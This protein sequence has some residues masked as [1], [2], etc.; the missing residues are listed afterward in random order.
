MFR[1]IFAQR[2]CVMNVLPAVLRG[3]FRSA[4]RTALLEKTSGT[5]QSNRTRVVRVWKLHV[6]LPRMLLLKLPRGGKVSKN[7][8]FDRFTK[9]TQGQSVVGF[10]GPERGSVCSRHLD[11]KQEDS[12]EKWAK[13]AGGIDLLG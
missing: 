1:D 4:M 10:F 7:A 8:F 2:A 3:A 13:R 12:V 9:F 6:L 11:A 5:E